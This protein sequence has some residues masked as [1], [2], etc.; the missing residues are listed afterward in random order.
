[1]KVESPAQLL[2]A[3]QWRRA[4]AEDR[5][6]GTLDAPRVMYLTDEGTTL[7]PAVIVDAWPDVDARLQDGRISRALI[8]GDESHRKGCASGCYRDWER[9]SCGT[10]ALLGYGAH[11]ESGDLAPNYAGWCRV[12][13]QASEPIPRAWLA[14]FV[15]ALNDEENTLYRD[16]LRRDVATF[17]YR[18]TDERAGYRLP[19]PTPDS[20]R[21]WLRDYHGEDR[22]AI[23]ADI[24]EIAA[25]PRDYPQG[26]YSRAAVRI[27]QGIVARRRV[28]S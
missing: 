23:G 28:T 14:A 21:Q 9:D 5:A 13:V 27:A 4:R 7:G 11:D 17:G 6:S 24:D 22:A 19:V 26:R 18:L 25:D 20:M 1:M 10:C 3:S 15:D 12:Y 8:L 16:A 2:T